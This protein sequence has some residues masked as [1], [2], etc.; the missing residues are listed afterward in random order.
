LQNG[1]FLQNTINRLWLHDTK[2]LLVP[3]DPTFNIE[4]ILVGVQRHGIFELAAIRKLN[5][6]VIIE[7]IDF[8]IKRFLKLTKPFKFDEVFKNW[9]MKITRQ[10]I[11]AKI[12]TN[13]ASKSDFFNRDPVKHCGLI[14]ASLDIQKYEANLLSPFDK[15]IWLLLLS[16]IL[17]VGLL[18]KFLSRPR[19]RR[20][21]RS[22]SRARD[23]IFA[24]LGYFLG[25]GSSLFR[26][27][28]LQ[29]SLLQLFVFAGLI[30]GT[31]YQS[32]LT[33]QVIFEGTGSQIDNIEDIIKSGRPVCVT[34]EFYKMLGD[35]PLYQELLQKSK[36]QK[37]LINAKECF[38][39]RTIFIVDCEKAEEFMLKS[40][41][42]F[43]MTKNAFF[44]KFDYDVHRNSAPGR[45]HSNS[46]SLEIYETGLHQYWKVKDKVKKDMKMAKMQGEND[47]EL[48][49]LQHLRAIFTV[50]GQLLTFS[51]IVFLA[52]ILHSRL[53][54]KCRN[55]A[56]KFRP[57]RV[58]DGWIPFISLRT[59]LENVRR[60]RRVEKTSVVVK[61]KAR[62]Q[63]SHKLDNLKLFKVE[64]RLKAMEGRV[65]KVRNVPVIRK[66]EQ[67]VICS[68]DETR[69]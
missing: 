56:K 63:G 59:K 33:A 36:P 57:K 34:Q 28:A 44:S 10:M 8:P 46:L 14:P 9:M 16:A 27:N 37:D 6:E 42:G 68:F 17:T 23:F 51:A 21:R 64:K 29:N 25:Q 52:E 67:S 48:V 31:L 47:L 45:E 53:S 1:Y 18:W 24:A 38:D 5:G 66:I 43:R 15:W 12:D 35:S 39:G 30:L 55:I 7:Q 41:V 62:P 58:P 2:V 13:K 54:E 11:T 32:Q 40:D 61:T 26:L 50:F 49:K 19:D 69:G 20:S 4:S 65:A 60:R 3:V 22:R